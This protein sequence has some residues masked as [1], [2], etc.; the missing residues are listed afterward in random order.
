LE[1]S[2]LHFVNLRF[3]NEYNQIANKSQIMRLKK[4]LWAFLF[5][6]GSFLNVFGSYTPKR[7]YLVS[8]EKIWLQIGDNLREAMV[9]LKDEKK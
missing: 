7:S 4:R 1:G 5:G 2:K 9:I 8:Q 3:N 6:M